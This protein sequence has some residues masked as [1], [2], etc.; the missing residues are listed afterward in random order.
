MILKNSDNTK[1]MSHDVDAQLVAIN[2]YF[3]NEIYELKRETSQLKLLEKTGKCENSE[4]I[5]TDILKSQ[6]CIL[7]ERIL[8]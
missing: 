5:L 4:S 6:I 8:L 1:N 7:Q 2:T 3:M